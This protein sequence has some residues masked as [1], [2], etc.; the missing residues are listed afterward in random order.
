MALEAAKL[1]SSN[2][3]TSAD[4]QQKQEELNLEAKKEMANIIQ[5]HNEQ[6]IDMEK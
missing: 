4:I 1:Q 5:K 2:A 3:K 6:I